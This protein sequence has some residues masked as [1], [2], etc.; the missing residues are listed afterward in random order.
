MKKICKHIAIVAALFA[1]VAVASSAV[2]RNRVDW[3]DIGNGCDVA[4][5]EVESH[6]YVVTKYLNYHGGGVS[7][8]HA[9]SC[10]CIDV[11]NKR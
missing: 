4:V 3:T 1:G 11:L 5:I 2:I 10:P 9:H 6:R 8:V 7:T